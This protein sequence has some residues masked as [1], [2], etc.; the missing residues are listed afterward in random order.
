MI[1]ITKRPSFKYILFGNLYLAEGLQFALST[2]ILILYFTE[3]NIS[4]ATATLVVGVATSPWIL[5]FIYGPITDFFIKYGRKPI[6]IF[7]GLLSGI[8]LLPLG[9]IDPSDALIPFTLLLFISHSG[10]MFLDVS[11]DAWAI[12]T[13]EYKE[14]GKVNAAMTGGLFL[15]WG[16]GSPVL[17]Y[18]ANNYGF[19]LS[20]LITS[21]LVFLTIILPIFV[22]EVKIKIKRKRIPYLVI[23]EFKKKNTLL[24]AF[25]SMITAM[26]FGLLLLI[27]PEY[28][29]NVLNLDIAQTGLI[30]GLYPI[31]T[32]FGAILGGFMA[33][34]WGR[35]FTLFIFLPFLI[36]FSAMLIFATTWLILAI[37]Y[38]TVGFLIGGSGYSAEAALFMDVTNPKIAATQYSFLASIHNFGDIIS[39]TV[40][41]SLVLMLGYNRVFLY[42]AWIIGPALLLLYFVKE[43]RH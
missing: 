28:M 16:L 37:I 42:A 4:V 24:V 43:K 31:G 8:C 11:A 34:K 21:F 30:A 12:Q 32:V 22:K 17:A 13:T 23:K 41:G 18:I 5:K 40:S 3:K 14:R 35:K 6:I 39:A 36:L 38:M 15:G 2:T 20:F 9:F 10:V 25:L 19:G 27:I 26:N 29:M 7:G 33:D 1:D